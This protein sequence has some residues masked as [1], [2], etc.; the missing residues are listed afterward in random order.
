MP[1]KVKPTPAPVPAP[2]PAAVS[3]LTHEVLT[4]SEAAAFLRVT[5]D[6]LMEEATA[7]RVPARKIGAEWRFSK[8]GLEQWLHGEESFSQSNG[9]PHQFEGLL[10]RLQDEI[11]KKLKASPPPP[12]PPTNWKERILSAAGIWKDEDEEEIEGMI[13]EMMKW[14][15]RPGS[16]RDR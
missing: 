3:V 12:P 5:V 14:R 15:G 9:I 8:S 2:V 7:G 4:P 16:G 6:Q 11:L 10:A 13:S 1:A